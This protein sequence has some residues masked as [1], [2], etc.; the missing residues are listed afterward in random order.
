MQ[1]LS[2]K[3]SGVRQRSKGCCLACRGYY[4]RKKSRGR[5]TIRTLT[6]CQSGS[7]SRSRAAPEEMKKANK[8]FPKRNSFL[9]RDVWKSNLFLHS[10]FI[11]FFRSFALN[12]TGFWKIHFMWKHGTSYFPRR[13]TYDTSTFIIFHW[14]W[15]HYIF[16]ALFFNIKWSHFHISFHFC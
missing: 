12:Y 14:N 3:N 9:R 6:Y 5:F 7:Y 8:T 16:V 10:V 13:L 4:N 1:L 15:F 2:R 11:S